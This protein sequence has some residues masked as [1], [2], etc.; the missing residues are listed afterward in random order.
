VKKIKA[1]PPILVAVVA[2]GCAPLEP[3]EPIVQDDDDSE[4]CRM[5]AAIG[6]HVK[7]VVCKPNGDSRAATDVENDRD[8]N[9]IFGDITVER[10]S[11]RTPPEGKCGNP[12]N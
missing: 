10:M 12:Q 5:E 4:I 2:T 7:E 11:D 9:G 3:V 8:I 6:T 1:V